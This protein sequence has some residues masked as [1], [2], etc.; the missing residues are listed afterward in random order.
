MTTFCWCV[1]S[2]NA[3]S[4]PCA[5]CSG[6]RHTRA[7]SH[8]CVD[9]RHSVT[10]LERPASLETT[11]TYWNATNGELDSNPLCS[12]PY[13][14]RLGRTRAIVMPLKSYITSHRQPPD[15][16][17]IKSHL[18][19]PEGNGRNSRQPSSRRAF[20]PLRGRRLCAPVDLAFAREAGP[21]L[22]QE[23]ISG[24]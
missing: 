18:Y 3:L 8:H 10:R 2:M 17:N 1:V 14:P 20:P 19:S 11:N 5:P 9:Y 12:C 4:H 24:L 6:V 13:A 15:V 22:L 16:Y 21:S 23:D 7:N